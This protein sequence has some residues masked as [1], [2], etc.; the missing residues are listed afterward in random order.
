[1][2]HPIE[3]VPAQVRILPPKRHDDRRSSR[4]FI[5]EGEARLPLEDEAL[6]L[7]AEERPVGQRPEDEAGARL[8]V[9]A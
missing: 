7:Q 9:T 8:D 2:D 4:R 1:M 5:V 3:R 6:N